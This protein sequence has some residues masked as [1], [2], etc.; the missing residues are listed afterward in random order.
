MRLRVETSR[1]LLYE[2]ARL[3]ARQRSTILELAMLKLHLSECFLQS[4]LD[5]VQIHGGVGYTSAL[6]L[7][8][9]VRDAVGGRIYSGTSEI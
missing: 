9:D 7:E 1:L 8:R 5:A 6:G 2:V 3:K 4:S